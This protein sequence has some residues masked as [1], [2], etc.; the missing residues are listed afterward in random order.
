MSHEFAAGFTCLFI[1]RL[2]AFSLQKTFV[3]FMSCEARVRWIQAHT[4][5]FL[6][7]CIH[8]CS[9]IKFPIFLL[10]SF[11]RFLFSFFFPNRTTE[12]SLSFVCSR[13][14]NPLLRTSHFSTVFNSKHKIWRLN[15]LWMTEQLFDI[16]FS[17]YTRLPRSME[18]ACPDKYLRKPCFVR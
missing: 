11:D 9:Y 14:E 7:T 15:L 13:F 8:I 17:I 5:C 2:L 6:S 12:S 18:K 3:M 4:L 10:P 1:R 16:S